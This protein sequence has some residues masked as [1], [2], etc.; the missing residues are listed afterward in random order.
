M[1]KMSLLIIFSFILMIKKV[2][3]CHTIDTDNQCP[4]FLAKIVN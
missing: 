2:D 4:K 1:K 3:D